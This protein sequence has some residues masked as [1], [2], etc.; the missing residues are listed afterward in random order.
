MKRSFHEVNFGACFESSRPMSV[1]KV[2]VSGTKGVGS[3]I[4]LAEMCLC[5]RRQGAQ[6]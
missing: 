4:R 6:M 5:R 1:R 3:G 2:V